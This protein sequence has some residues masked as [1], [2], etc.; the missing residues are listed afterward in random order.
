[1]SNVNCTFQLERRLNLESKI[2]NLNQTGVTASERV[3][4]MHASL[5]GS[6]GQSKAP[7]TTFV[8]GL[9]ALSLAVHPQIGHLASYI[10]HLHPLQLCG[11]VYFLKKLRKRVTLLWLCA[12][13]GLPPLLDSHC[14]KLPQMELDHSV[15]ISAHEGEWSGSAKVIN[16]PIHGHISMPRYCLE[17]IGASSTTFFPLHFP[18]DTRRPTL[19]LLASTLHVFLDV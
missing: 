18:F 5:C 15:S 12:G 7:P 6:Q 3:E 17:F 19:F 16:D 9:L 11:S 10:A 1:V 2:W 4:R 8:C 13:L 14:L